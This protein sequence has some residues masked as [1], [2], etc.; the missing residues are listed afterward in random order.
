MFKKPELANDQENPVEVLLQKLKDS[1][2]VALVHFY[3]LAGRL[4]T[5]KEESPHSH[6]VFIDCINSPG[7][8]FVHSKVELRISDI[9]LPTYVPSVVHSFFDHDRAV[10][11]DGHTMSLLTVQ[12]TELRDGVFIG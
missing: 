2:S 8:K 6:V 1:L 7:A 5:K 3:P 9:V 10:V 12:V 11:Y 4:V